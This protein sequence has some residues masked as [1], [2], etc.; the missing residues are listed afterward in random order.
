MPMMIAVLVIGEILLLLLIL[1]LM[2]EVVILRGDNTALRQLITVPPVPSILGDRLPS[3]LIDRL[4]PFVQ[5]FMD[6]RLTFRRVV[7]GWSEF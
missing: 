3:I 2:R 6:T 7:G 5:Q 1:G 4:Q